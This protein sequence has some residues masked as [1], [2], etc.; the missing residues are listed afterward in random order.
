MA[1]KKATTKRKTT[2]KTKTPLK[3]RFTLSRQQKVVLGSFLFFLGIALFFAFVSFFFNWKID[4][5]EI[6]E[7]PN[8]T[9]SAKNWLSISG[10]KVSDFFIFKGFGI[11]ALILPILI[12]ITGVYLFFDLN[13][14]KLA[15]FWFWGTLVMLWIS[16]IFGFVQKESGLLAGIIGYEVNDF[17]QDYIGFIGT[18]LVLAFFAIVYIVVRL[19]YT[20]EKISA[21]LKK[22]Q[23]D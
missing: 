6:S 23:K 21:S 15:G 4:Q 7:F 11:S 19:R 5:S 10:A 3:E 8:R 12:S 18:V 1:K 20:P 2:K 17:M 9:A 16:V 13:R 22:T 14:K